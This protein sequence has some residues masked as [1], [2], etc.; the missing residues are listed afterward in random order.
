M[1]RPVWGMFQLP[2]ECSNFAGNVPSFLGNV[3][4]RG[5]NVPP[6]WGMFQKRSGTFVQVDGTFPRRGGSS[7]RGRARL[8]VP[9]GAPSPAKAQRLD[10]PLPLKVQED[11][12]QGRTV[13]RISQSPAE[14]SLLEFVS[15]A[16]ESLLDV[17]AEIPGLAPFRVWRCGSQGLGRSGRCRRSP[18]SGR[19]PEAVERLDLG[20]VPFLEHLDAGAELLVELPP[21]PLVLGWIQ[22]VS[23]TSLRLPE[24]STRELFRGW[25]R[26][27]NAGRRR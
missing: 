18:L 1:F 23:S 21:A 8:A 2:G 10:P 26:L 16:R 17:V 6:R 3:P 11:A 15:D 20:S 14:V 7:A 19:R 12:V 27:E 25:S 4:D 5:E 9:G 24:D 22:E 13:R